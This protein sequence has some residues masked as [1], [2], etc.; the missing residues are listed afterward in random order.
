MGPRAGRSP[1]VGPLPG[2]G[3]ART[4]A[5]AVPS[6]FDAGPGAPRRLQ[7]LAPEIGERRGIPA[8]VRA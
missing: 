8:V 3:V 7:A 1:I 2:R 6:S 5:G 4:G